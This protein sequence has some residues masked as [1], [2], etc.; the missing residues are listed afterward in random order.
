[1]QSNLLQAAIAL[2]DF[3]AAR[4]PMSGEVPEQVGNDHPTSMPTSAYATADGHINVAAVGQQD[5]A[6]RLRG[7]RPPRPGRRDPRFKTA[8]GRAK[9][10][11][12]LNAE[13]TAAW[14][15]RPAAEWVAILNKAGVPCGPI[16]RMDQVFA[17]PQVKHMQAPRPRC[18]NRR[19]GELTSSTSR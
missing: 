18:S 19:L 10:R 13:M 5:V 2:L 7:D 8:E 16:Y 3:Q 14:R 15:R 9:N 4:Y 17:D 6:H 1:M 12:A 11:K